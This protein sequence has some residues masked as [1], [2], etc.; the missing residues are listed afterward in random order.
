MSSSLEGSGRRCGEASS[1]EGSPCSTQS[2]GRRLC[3]GRTWAPGGLDLYVHVL[4]LLV[5][6]TESVAEHA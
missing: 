6:S 3:G 2:K 1:Q 4:T 5:F